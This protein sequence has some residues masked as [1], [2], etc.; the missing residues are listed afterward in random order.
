MLKFA[1][2]AALLR[3]LRKLREDENGK[4]KNWI[5]GSLIIILWIF[6]VLWLAL[7]AYK[8]IT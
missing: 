4:P 2:D 3:A 5:V 6:I 7:S 1:G 8:F